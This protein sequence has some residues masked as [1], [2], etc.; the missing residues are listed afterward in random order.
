MRNE[1]MPQLVMQ[2]TRMARD[3][4]AQPRVDAFHSIPC[5]GEDSFGRP[6][7]ICHSLEIS[8]SHSS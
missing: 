5:R 7:S 4:G 3:L 1:A 8:P 2:R 6:C